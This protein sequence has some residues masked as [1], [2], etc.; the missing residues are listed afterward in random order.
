MNKQLRRAALNAA[1]NLVASKGQTAHLRSAVAFAQGVEVDRELGVIKNAAIMTCGPASGHGFE[2]DATTIQQVADLINAQRGVKVRF[3]HPEPKSD[4]EGNLIMP[5]DLGTDVGYIRN[6]RVVGDACRGDIYLADYARNLPSIGNARDYL[7]DKAKSDPTGFGLSAVIYFDAEVVNDAAGQP[8]SLV[9]RVS[10]VEAVDFVGKPAANPHGLLSAVSPAEKAAKIAE[11]TSE[12]LKAIRDAL[13]TP[14]VGVSLAAPVIN[15]PAATP[16]AR[17]SKGKLMDPKV[18]QYLQ[19]NHALAADASDEDAQKMFDGLSADEQAKASAPLADK[20]APA[21]QLRGKAI[22]DAGDEFLAL[23][24]KRV[25]QLQQLGNTL[26]VDKGEVQ[27]AIA[28]G[29]DVM[30]AR[31]RFLKA[32]QKTA[33]PVTG[34]IR[35]GEDQKLKMLQAALPDAICLRGGTRRFYEADDRGRVVRDENGNAVKGK[36]HE[37]AQKFVGLSVLDM[38]RQWLIGHGAPA[39]EVHMLS[40]PQLAELMGPRALARRFPQVAMLAQSTGDFANVV[41]DAQNKSLRMGYVEATRTWN[42]WASRGTAPDFKNIN[43]IQTSE[44]PTPTQRQEGQPIVYTVLTDS[45][46]TYTLSE[47]TSGV[48]LTRRVLIN[49][50]MGALTTVP[51]KQGQSAARLEDDVAYSVLLANAAMADTGALFN[52]T[53]IATT[54]GHNNL[55]SSGGGAPTVTTVAATEKLVMLQKGPKNAAILNLEP[56]IMIVPIAI[57]TVSQ[58]FMASNVDPSKS[59]ATPNPYNGKI[60]VVPN[61]RLDNGVTVNGTTYSGQ[62]DRV[63]PARRLQGRPDRH[64]RGFVPLGRAR[65][66]AEAGD[67]LRHGRPEVCRP[68]RR[69][70]QAPRLPR[71]G[72]EPRRLSLTRFP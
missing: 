6:A 70:R 19:A 22:V 41:L 10:A 27:L 23:E 65:A 64:R 67:R 60:Q 54:G 21:T 18:K 35:V 49:D 32:L 36:V 42:L 45:K 9:A 38:H 16:A 57:K 72:Q 43:R 14:V 55:I 51:M 61:A 2:C 31:T 17:L 53:A 40:R 26:N 30:K 24:G 69:R 29:D 47:Y 3:R 39:D 5:D 68:T 7:L 12:H 37:M 11:V 15:K 66:G 8:A 56:K 34:A 62:F 13:A 58:Q 50:D 52:S 48:I 59:N 71:H 4:G 20:S 25:A 1:D 46:E 44:V 33:Q 63:V 28:E